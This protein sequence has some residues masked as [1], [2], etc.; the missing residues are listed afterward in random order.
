MGMFQ[1]HVIVSRRVVSGGLKRV[2]VFQMPRPLPP[3]HMVQDVESAMHRTFV[4]VPTAPPK[5][6]LD[7]LTNHQVGD[8]VFINLEN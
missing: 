5:K 6:G 2:V 7:D 4:N 8:D 1:C 3:R